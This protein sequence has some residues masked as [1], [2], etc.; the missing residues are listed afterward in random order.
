MRAAFVV[1]LSRNTRPA[2]NHF[3]GS[4]EEID[5]GRELR[6]H[7]TEELI[8]FLGQSFDAIFRND[9]GMAKEV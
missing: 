5:S 6:F 2:Q 7:S 3:E 1:R 8:H 9:E 4:V